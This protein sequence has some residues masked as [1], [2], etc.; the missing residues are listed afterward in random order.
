M[1]VTGL[2]VVLTLAIL[3]T[4][5]IAAPSAPPEIADTTL[6]DLVNRP[7]EFANRHV[8]VRGTVEVGLEYFGLSNDACSS[9]RS[10]GARAWLDVAGE[11]EAFTYARGWS[12]QRFVKATVSGELAGAGPPVH[13]QTPSKLAP[14]DDQ[15]RDA[16]RR[17][18]AASKETGVKVIVTGRF[19]YAGDGLLIR[20][21]DGHFSLQSAY[22]HLNCCPARIV[23]EKAEVSGETQ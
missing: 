18:L 7:L 19:D 5:M 2:P 14:L 3:A 9:A 17:A 23:V 20:S 15:Q 16:L 12:M 6:C 21:S 22:G 8:R 13:W 4:S 11:D 10:T 1:P